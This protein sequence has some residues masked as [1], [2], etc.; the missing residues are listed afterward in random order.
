VL[1]LVTTTWP[2]H[3]DVGR[4]ILSFSASQGMQTTKL[5]NLIGENI[6]LAFRM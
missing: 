4:A 5:K 1:S 3:G 2:D 6:G